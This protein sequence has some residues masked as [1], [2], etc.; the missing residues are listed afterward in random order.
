MLKVQISQDHF[1]TQVRVFLV[2]LALGKTWLSQDWPLDFHVLWGSAGRIKLWEQFVV[3]SKISLFWQSI[4]YYILTWG[5]CHTRCSSERPRCHSQTPDC[6]GEKR[7]AHALTDDGDTHRPYGCQLDTALSSA[8]A[9]S[10]GSLWPKAGLSRYFH[11]VTSIA[12][13]PISAS[14]VLACLHPYRW[15]VQMIQAEWTSCDTVKH[16]LHM[17]QFRRRLFPKIWTRWLEAWIAGIRKQEQ[18]DR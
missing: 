13:F 16:Y 10:Q 8:G 7:I 9:T 15:E 2:E 3:E 12:H 1:P 11:C 14:T 4:F 17:S 6:E 5:R 18:W